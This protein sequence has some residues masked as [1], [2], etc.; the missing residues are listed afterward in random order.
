MNEVKI[1]RKRG[2]EF[3]V[4]PKGRRVKSKI[5]G[6]WLQDDFKAG[7][8]QEYREI[9]ETALLLPKVCG[10]LIWEKLDV[11]ATSYCD[12]KDEFDEKIGIDV[13]EAKLYK[14]KHMKLAKI[15]D[16]LHRTLI[17]TAIVAGELCMKHTK[18][19]EAIEKDLCEHY[20]RMPL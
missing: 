7:I 9:L 5:T 4:I 16:R 17:E 20:G 3:K 11:E 12:E 13:C 2:K 15:Y 18:K 19:A 1:V 14:N 10:K 8:K 6:K